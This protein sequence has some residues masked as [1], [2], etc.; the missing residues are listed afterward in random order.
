MAKI[1]IIDDDKL[2][3]WSLTEIFSQEGYE[4]NSVA[5]IEDALTQTKQN[6]YHL[7][8]ADLEISEENGIEM[9]KKIRTFQPKTKII[10]LSAFTRNQIEAELDN[11]N[12][13]SIIEKP[14]KSEQIRTSA[15]EA[16]VESQ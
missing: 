12:I 13:F 7:I 9:L 10:V 6:L 15:R 4:V 1:L 2:I 5:S 14:F 11:L 16:L 3:R 8:F